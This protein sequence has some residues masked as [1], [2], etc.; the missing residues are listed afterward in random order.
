MRARSSPI[1]TSCL[2]L[3]DLLPC[4]RSAVLLFFCATIS[5]EEYRG[6]RRM[7]CSRRRRKAAITSRCPGFSI[8]ARGLRAQRVGHGPSMEF[9]RS[10]RFMTNGCTT[11]RAT[12][13]GDDCESTLSCRI[14][15]DTACFRGGRA[16]GKRLAWPASPRDMPAPRVLPGVSRKV[17][18]A[19]VDF[20]SRAG[21][22]PYTAAL[23]KGK[24][25]APADRPRDWKAQYAPI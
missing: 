4:H 3:V 11:T 15:N 1:P 7:P 23:A 21:M 9:S 24:T 12:G 8:L 2:G 10:T 14:G 25:H 17:L 18:P 6:G 13:T 22:Q 20:I 16:C 19:L 5:A